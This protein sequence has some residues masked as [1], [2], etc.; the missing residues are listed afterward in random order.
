MMRQGPVKAGGEVPLYAPQ[1]R[2]Y[3]AGG[4]LADR[5]VFVRQRIDV[6]SLCMSLTVP[7][8]FFIA[9]YGLMMFEFRYT[10]PLYSGLLVALGL[11]VVLGVGAAGGLAAQARR[12]GQSGRDPTWTLF[13]FG[14]LLAAWVLA[15][16]YG[17]QTFSLYT[18]LYYDYQHMATYLDVSPAAASGKQL[19]DAGQVLFVNGTAVD[20]RRST[21][22]KN[23]DTYCVAPITLPGQELPFYDFWAVGLGCCTAGSADFACGESRSPGA[24]GGLRLLREDQR[25]FFRL[26]VAQAESAH[27]IKAAHPLFFHWTDDPAAEAASLLDDGYRFFFIGML[28]HF[29]WQLL[30]VGLAAAAFAKV[31]HF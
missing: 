22:F 3:G 28:A 25:G 15:Y 29:A 8:L 31:G 9:I 4:K 19:M 6:V 23:V 14:T 27:Q 7:W 20:I 16:V 2:R 10:H 30:C 24:R 18:R 5:T 13:L 12:R 11:L 26:A 1:A 17:R 21:G